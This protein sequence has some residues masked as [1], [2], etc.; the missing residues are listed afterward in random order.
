[1]AMLKYGQTPGTKYAQQALLL[2]T[3][4]QVLMIHLF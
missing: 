4:D 1:M 3:S 2:K